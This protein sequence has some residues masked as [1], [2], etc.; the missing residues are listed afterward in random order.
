[1]VDD[2]IFCKIA[3]KKIPS[4]IQYE[5]DE[6]IAFDDINPKAPIHILIVPKK[7]LGSI[8]ALDESEINIASK[9]I[10]AARKIA[11]EKGIRSFRLIFN[12]GKDAGMEIDHLH[13]HLLAG[14]KLG[15]M[16]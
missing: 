6:I 2:C 14:G 1:M 13:L 9:M 15:R 16:A 7:H 10:G 3:A 11:K 5:N 4:K 8:L 12:S